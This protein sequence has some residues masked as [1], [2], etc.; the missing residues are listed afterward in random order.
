MEMK[1]E[2]LR[3]EGDAIAKAAELLRKGELVALPTE[4]VYGIAADARNGEAVAK[5]FVAKGRPQD[6]P[7]IVH[8]TGPEMLPGLVSEV[9]ERAQLLMAAFCPG[10]L[11]IIMPR[12]PEVA[13]ECCAGLDTVGIRMPSHPVARAVIE[14][15]GC[16]FAAPSANLSGKPSPTNAQDVFTDMNGRLPLILD[17]GECDV[18]VESTVISVVGEKPTLFRPGHITLEDLERALGEEVEVSKAI[19]EK[20]PEGAVV[21]SPGMKY[22]HY[23]P[24]ADVTLLD[25]NFEQFKAYVEAHMDQNPSCL[26]FTGE[27]EKLG[28]PC[29]EYGR[30]GDGAD[31]AKHIFR[32]LRALDEQG[33]GIVYAR[34]PK[35]D[36][37]S[38]AVYNRLPMPTSSRGRSCSRPRRCCRCWRSGSGKRSSA[39]TVHWTVGFWPTAPSRRR[40]ERRRWISSPTRRSSAASG[41]PNRPRRKPGHRSSCWMVQSSSGPRRKRNAT[42]WRW[43]QL[44]LKQAWP[45]SPS[46]TASRLIWQP[47]A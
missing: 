41:W 16:A 44:P 9:P 5:I 33:D 1:T 45:A 35:K 26:C 43:S 18:G 36:G 22:K 15:S 2:I 27:A 32:S 10:P 3:A 14:Q 46:G 47:A 11:T 30:E 24:K 34:C 8:V 37:L 21:R 42:V 25:G 29:V 23:A 4:T 6:N 7:L 38:M 19:L 39:R 20:L 40:K 31:Q 13:A 28:V 17:G 12:G